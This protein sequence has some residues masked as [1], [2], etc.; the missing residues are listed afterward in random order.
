M[1]YL[2]LLFSLL[3]LHVQAQTNAT[4]LHE[5]V[6]SV[7]VTVKDLFGREA[8]GKVVITQF[9]PDGDGPFPILILNHGR[10]VSNHGEPPRFRF[11][12]QVRFFIRRGF[13][14]FVP[15]RIGYGAQG[16]SFDPESSGNCTSADYAPMAE[17]ASTEILAVLDYAKQ[18]PYAGG[19]ICTSKS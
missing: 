3:S 11:P 6:A 18:R 1:R 19:I 17:A 4:D 2:I 12:A 16:T 8:S 9:K 7:D 5:S 14:V 15:T 13:A 10:S